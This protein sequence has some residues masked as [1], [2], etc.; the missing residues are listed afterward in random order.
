MPELGLYGFMG[1]PLLKLGYLTLFTQF[2][3]R[4]EGMQC[5]TY[6]NVVV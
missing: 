6:L 2:R 1:L 5:A 4:L 3:P